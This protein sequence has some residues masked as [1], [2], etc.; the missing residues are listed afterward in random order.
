MA[1]AHRPSDI[2]RVRAVSTAP[3]RA[4]YLVSDGAEIWD[5]GPDIRERGASMLV[6]VNGETEAADDPAGCPICGHRPEPRQASSGLASSLSRAVVAVGAMW[7]CVP[8][9]TVRQRRGCRRC[10]APCPE[11]RVPRSRG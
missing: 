6:R 9:W 3:R 10:G 4:L 2:A 1:V 11:E 5:R 7:M 8:S